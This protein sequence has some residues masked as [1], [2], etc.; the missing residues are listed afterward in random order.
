MSAFAHDNVLYHLWSFLDSNVMRLHYNVK[1][2]PMAANAL[3]QTR[4]DS[5]VKERAALVLELFHLPP[6]L[7]RMT[8]GS[9][10]R[11][12]RQSTIRVR[13]LPMRR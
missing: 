7:Q 3:V 6:T 4:I 11:C 9:A 2:E 1:G 12:R 8:C 5:G 10:R 13:P